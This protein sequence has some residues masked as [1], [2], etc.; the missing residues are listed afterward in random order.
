MSSVKVITLGCSKNRVDSEHLMRQLQA[1]SFEIIPEE[2][3]RPADILVLNTC[4]FIQDAKEESVAAIFDAVDRKNRGESSRVYV[5]GCLSQRYGNELRG[6][7][8]EVDGFFGASDKD[9]ALMTEALGGQYDPVLA[10]QRYLTTPGHYAYL[11]IS[12]GCDR[13]CAY[14]AI[15]GIRGRHVS[16]PMDELVEEARL[17]A[18]KGVCELIVIAQ[19]TTYYGLD[20]YGKRMIA[21]LLHRLSEISGIRWIRLHY[22][23]PNAFPD[24]LLD[25]MASNP[26]ICK[27][28]DIPLQH[29]STKV[30]GKMRR[31]ITGKETSDLIRK[32]RERVPG[33]VLRTTLI[34]GHPGE[35]KREFAELLDF[36]R[37]M[38][39]ER[40]GAFAYS[41]EEGTYGA[42]NYKDSVSR[43][44]KLRRLDE[45]MSL[46]RGISA[47]CNA[48]RVGTRTTVVAD[49]VADG[50]YVCRSMNES[51]EVDGEIYVEIP[52]DEKEGA[53]SG[54]IGKFFEV[55]ILR[56]GDYDLY[57][58]II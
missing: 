44:E 39:F 52:E 34:V 26:K 18:A 21:P 15:P 58:K 54:R 27:Y 22:S 50:Y 47:S 17:L 35:G 1:A 10:Q 24:D 43:K 32:I 8:P 46:Q 9:L 37:E 2:D 49:A 23:Y 42:E 16:V 7:I 51:P 41:E 48:T 14:C 5:F 11:K 29:C 55:E 56:A 40:M 12:E 3:G 6:L 20:L 31:N 53:V 45:L 38:R 19:D 25:E 30:L 4:A 13:K 57:G 33:I 28:L 36:V